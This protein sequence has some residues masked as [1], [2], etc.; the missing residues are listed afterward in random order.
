MQVF[1]VAMVGASHGGLAIIDML[2]RE[3]PRQLRMKLIGVADIDQ[4][5]PGMKRA[6]E[7]NIFTTTDVDD[8]WFI[9]M[10]HEK[11]TCVR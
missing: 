3:R 2:T 5:A 4:E 8:I 1:N 11:D 6:R 7:L 9:I 10:I